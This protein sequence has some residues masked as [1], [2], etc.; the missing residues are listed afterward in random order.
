[1]DILNGYLFTRLFKE[2]EKKHSLGD[3]FI[4]MVFPR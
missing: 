2:K 3:V 1:M 4:E